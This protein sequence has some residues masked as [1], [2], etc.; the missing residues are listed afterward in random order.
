MYSRKKILIIGSGWY[1][2]HIASILK[3]KH[4]IIII[5]KNNDIFS[6]SSYFNQNRLHLGYHYCRNYPTRNL[7]QQ[8]YNNFIEKYN[9]LVDNINNNYYII[10]NKSIIDFKTYLS[11]YNY[12]KFN[13][14]LIENNL[15][16]NIDGEIIQVNEKVINSDRAYKYFKE[17]LKD[18]KII[19]NEIFINYKKEKDIINV[20]TNNT[21]NTKYEC[22]ILLDCT[23]NQLGLSKYNYTYELTCSLLYKKIQNTNFDAITIMDGKFSSLYPREINNLI[24]TLTDV[25]FTPIISSKKFKDILEYKLSEALHL[26]RN[27]NNQEELEQYFESKTYCVINPEIMNIELFINHIKNVENIYI[28][29]G[30]SMVNLCYVKPNTNIY[31]LQSLSYKQEDIFSIF[32]FLRN[33]TNLYVIKCNN[34]NNIIIDYNKIDINFNHDIIPLKYC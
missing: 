8:N 12:E 23:Y 29:W 28:T 1:G 27:L 24:Y 14:K 22:D 13:F 34:D 16:E 6:G 33:Y 30:G 26:P 31:L 3:D 25:E 19:Y 2:C 15:F 9:D 21:N 32:K 7:C 10:S 20:F 18:V 11:I 4:D 17:Q 5:E